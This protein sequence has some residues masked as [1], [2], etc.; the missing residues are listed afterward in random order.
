MSPKKK[1]RQRK[2]LDRLEKQLSMGTKTKKK[3]LG[4]QTSLTDK[5]KKRIKGEIEILKKVV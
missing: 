1:E 3:T 4:E 2:A 5:D